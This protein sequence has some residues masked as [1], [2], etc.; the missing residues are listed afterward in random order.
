M[1][2]VMANDTS[3]TAD[4]LPRA[5][6][7]SDTPAP[8]RRGSESRSENTFV[9]RVGRYAKVGG[10]MSGL[11]ARLAADRYLGLKIERNEHADELRAALGNIKGPLMKVAQLAATIPEALPEEYARELRQLQT[12][13][14]PM[15]W[16]F[17]KRRMA[18]ELGRDWQGRFAEFSHEAA[19]AAS[20]GQVHRARSHDGRDLACK[21]QYPDMG[22]AVEADLR[23]LKVILSIYENYDKAIRT[24]HIHGELADRLREE[25]DYAR[26]ARHMALYRDMLAEE[27]QVSVPEV[28][29]DL[30]TD[31]LL[32]MT[33]LQGRPIMDFVDD[34]LE[35]RNQLAVNMFR[36]WYVPFYYYGTIHGDP[37][38]GNYTVREDG[39]INLL[40]FGCVRV[41]RP[42]FVQGVIDLYH[43]LRNDDRDLA[44]HAY[45]VWGFKNLSSEVIEVLNVW[46]RFIYGAVMEDKERLLGETH[47][48]VYG[49]ET[50]QKVHKELRETG[51]VEV[52][53]EFVFMDRAAL[54][55]GSVFIHLKAEI[56]WYKLFNELIED[57]DASAM[58][59]RQ[60]EM[61]ARHDVPIPD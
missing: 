7:E 24:H 12:N 5:Q 18:T 51:G 37:H 35:V 58:E 10:A 27:P 4:G 40:D 36:A 3:T 45:E 54:G 14:P 29:F 8:A 52:P 60:A 22:S 49:R 57:F 59:R 48:G 47:N 50:A 61:L 21:L 25:L 9:G 1:S 34:P 53:R 56:N 43:A 55:L 30:S 17:V 42:K 2:L 33:W 28:L 44:V 23:Q 19:S 41:F 11:A 13:A 16:S 31:R 26:E 39:G 6:A 20:L 32:T 46:A 15:G 38:M